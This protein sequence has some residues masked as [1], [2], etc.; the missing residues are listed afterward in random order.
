M[1]KTKLTSAFSLVTLVAGIGALQADESFSRYDSNGDGSVE[2]RELA[3]AKKAEEFDRM[4]RNRDK[5]ITSEEFAGVEI[6]K[7]G[8]MD[9]FATPDFAA[10]DADSNSQ[11]SLVEFGAAVKSLVVNVDASEDL[12]VSEEEYSAAIMKAKA[13]RLPLALKAPV[14]KRVRARSLLPRSRTGSCLP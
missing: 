2:Y 4:D 3:L 1:I 13:A 12:K 5:S 14:Q 9:L 10:M 7:V 8:E 11:V 6:A